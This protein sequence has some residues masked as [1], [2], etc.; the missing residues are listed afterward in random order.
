MALRKS[1]G[2][3][4]RK[5]EGPEED[6][7]STERRTKS[8]NLDPWGLPEIEPPTKEPA[9]AG[10]KP[11]CTYVADVHLG[12]YVGPPKTGGGTVP[13]SVAYLWTSSL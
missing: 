12:L 2:R 5:T 10:P 9:W 4:G 3:V 1:C 13:E 8:T 11:P 6:R 7:D